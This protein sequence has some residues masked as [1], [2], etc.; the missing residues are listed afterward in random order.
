MQQ[1]ILY[2][3]DIAEL[4]LGIAGS[5]EETG[6]YQRA[7][8]LVAEAE[9]IY[10]YLDD[11]NYITCLAHKASI[12][13]RLGNVDEAE[14]CLLEHNSYAA[15][16]CEQ[17]PDAVDFKI[18]YVYSVSRL[19]Q[20][21]LSKGDYATALTLFKEA[22][23]LELQLHQL[24]PDNKE[25][26][27]HYI[28]AV[29]DLGEAYTALGQHDIAAGYI[30]EFYRLMDGYVAIHPSAVE[31]K[32][33][34]VRSLMKLGAA[35]VRENEFLQ[36]LVYYEEAYGLLAVLIKNDKGLTDIKQEYMDLLYEMGNIY[37]TINELGLARKYFSLASNYSRQLSARYPLNIWFR[38][39]LSSSLNNLGAVCES[40]KLYNEALA[41]FQESL[42]VKSAV[43]AEKPGLTQFDEGLA[44]LH[45]NM[46]DTY[47]AL[48]NLKEALI[49]YRYFYEI[50]E[51][52]GN[53][54]K[55][56][57]RPAQLMSVALGRLSKVYALLGDY[58]TALKFAGR[59]AVVC[60]QLCRLFP[61]HTELKNDLAVCYY[62][63][64]ELFSKLSDTEKALRYYQLEY[65]MVLELHQQ[66]P[67]SYKYK[68]GF[69]I[70]LY[71]TGLACNVLGMYD[72][73]MTFLQSYNE[74]KKEMYAEARHDKGAV[75][76]AKNDFAISHEYLGDTFMYIGH[77][78][79]GIAH[80][81]QAYDILNEL[82]AE[83]ENGE[84]W[85][86]DRVLIYLN[87]ASSSLKLGVAWRIVN[88]GGRGYLYLLQAKEYLETV[89]KLAPDMPDYRTY[90]EEVQKHIDAY[91]PF[92]NS[93][94][95]VIAYLKRVGH[96]MLS[97]LKK[98]HLR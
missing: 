36:S 50:T 59:S 42:E 68:M 34:K 39:M 81:G 17:H 25:R 35:Y 94:R 29:N 75:F 30:R 46:G 14:A 16:Y 43:T 2:D 98:R 22:H 83:L 71:K 91:N 85:G 38:N 74:I 44:I 47:I 18:A 10:L 70:S 23:E 52:I 6:N 28:H 84:I 49:C 64:G 76:V 27:L 78:M 97:A 48:G 15:M 53:E 24:V 62:D 19:A 73:A 95:K 12:H 55:T 96:D 82:R 32:M 11:K 90:M 31:A 9:E 66:F 1:D 80:F 77:S 13:A 89:H 54:T 7:I 63:L 67:E 60:R 45:Q 8:E 86:G 5:Y 65:F 87:L 69:S 51:G 21:R 3:R 56:I 92:I 79:E 4:M 20:L 93:W 72:E 41:C 61:L 58:K 40:L 88:N 57:P 37:L 26:Y 33:G